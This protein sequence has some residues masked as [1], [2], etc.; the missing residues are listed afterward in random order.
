MGRYFPE[1]SVISYAKHLLH[2]KAQPS[3]QPSSKAVKIWDKPRGWS[4]GCL[5]RTGSSITQ[6]HADSGV[7]GDVK[8]IRKFLSRCRCG[9][10]VC[11]DL[12][13]LNDI[14]N[15]H[16]KLTISRR[17]MEWIYRGV[18]WII[19]VCLWQ[20]CPVFSYSNGF[21]KWLKDIYASYSPSLIMNDARLCLLPLSNSIRQSPTFLSLY[22]PIR[23][24]ASSSY[25]ACWFSW[26]LHFWNSSQ[27]T[28]A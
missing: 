17:A 2:R 3:P 13:W 10:F 8:Y 6:P 1:Q 9:R 16:I 21:F 22:L 11:V 28:R 14:N 12:E 18:W 4:K 5:H 26:T 15:Y 7:C 24:R 25:I 27:A 19:L 20:F 23:Y